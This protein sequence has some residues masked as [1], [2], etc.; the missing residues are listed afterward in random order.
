MQGAKTRGERLRRLEMYAFGPLGALPVGEI[1]GFHIKP[2]LVA[3]LPA[4]ARTSLEHLLVD[5][6]SVLDELWRDGVLPENP[7]KRVRVPGAARQDRR[8]R[9]VLTDDEFTRLVDWPALQPELKC[10]F[11]TSRCLGGARTSDLHAWDWSNVDTVAWASA[12]LPRPKTS[13]RDRLALPDVL[14]PALRNWWHLEGRPP[15]GPVFPTREGPS[16]GAR[17]GKMSHARELRKALW[18]AGVRRGPSRAECELQTN[19]AETLRADFHSLRRAYNT[20]LAAAG[21]NVQTAMKLAGHRSPVTHMRYVLPS[22]PL[23]VPKAALPSGLAASADRLGGVSGWEL[24]E[25]A[26]RADVM[27][28]GAMRHLATSIAARGARP[29]C[30]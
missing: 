7:A 12:H 26:Q 25:R 27:L 18:Q 1:R 29:R 22:A 23:E 30:R 4:L 10:L 8:P 21:V 19:T 14:V 20:G 9:A 2:V 3:A 17:R 16:A 6:G 24:I 5:I 28:A 11:L 15:K 13:T